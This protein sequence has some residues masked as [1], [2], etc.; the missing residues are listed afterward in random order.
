M[1]TWVGIALM[2]VGAATGAV[3]AINQGLE[4]ERVGVFNSQMAALDADRAELEGQRQALAVQQDRLKYESSVINTFANR[5]LNPDVGTPIELLKEAKKKEEEALL[6]I[7]LNKETEVAKFRIQQVNYRRA[8]K[9]ARRAAYTKALS[10]SLKA[11]GSAT[12]L[13][14]AGGG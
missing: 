8:G 14:G 2:A 1:A 6:T 13:G 4:A 5:G 9:A 10:G 3:G 12:L 7:D 11:A